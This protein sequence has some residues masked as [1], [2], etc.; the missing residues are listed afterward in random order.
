MKLLYA[1]LANAAEA[2]EGGRW[3]G[4]GIDFDTLTLEM[5]PSPPY[6]F[7]VVM[8]IEVPPSEVQ[9]NLPLTVSIEDPLGKKLVLASEFPVVAKPHP[10]DPTHSANVLVILNAIASF[11]CP[12]EHAVVISVQGK[13]LK[14]LPLHVKY[15]GAS[16]VRAT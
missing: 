1:V 7:V 9:T 6:S 13:K 10:M 14:A 3:H 5:V 4:F 16:S 12:G 2:L 15:A 11:Q 8:K